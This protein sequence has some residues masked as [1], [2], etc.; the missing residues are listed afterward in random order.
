MKDRLPRY[1]LLLSLY[2]ALALL[3]NNLEEIKLTAGLRV[4]AFS[5]LGAI[6]LTG[7]LKLVFKD[8]Q[9]A[10]LG[11]ALFLLLFFSYGHV[12]GALKASAALGAVVG[13]HRFL[14]PLWLAL[15]LGLGW[16]T[17]YRVKDRGN[18]E[19]GLN[20]IAVI[21]LV[22]PVYQIIAF[23]FRAAAIQA[24]QGQSAAEAHA[25]SLPEGQT[26]PDIYYIILDA[27]ARDDSLLEDYHLDNSPFLEHL[28]ELG[29]FVARCSQS[30]YAQTKL[31]LSSALTMNYLEAFYDNA[32][33]GNTS[34]IGIENYILHPAAREML[35]DLGYQTVAFET[36]FTWSQ[37]NDA[38]YYFSPNQGLFEKLG[39]RG[40]LN[41]FET[42][43]T[44]ST[45][46]VLLT[47]AGQKIPAT[48]PAGGGRSQE[49]HRQRVLY[50]L[51]KLSE[52]PLIPGPKFVFAHI[53]SPHPPY[54]FG[55]D[56]G[57]AIF[58][59]NEVQAYA[60]QVVYLNGRFEAII[61]EILA[62]SETEPIIIIQ[63]DHGGTSAPKDARMQILNAYYFP[64]EGK[65][66]LYA[67]ITP[68]NSFRLVF[69][70]YFGG[71]F[72][73]LEDASY[74][75]HYNAPYEYE[76]VPVVREGCEAK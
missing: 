11:A 17:L 41:D 33:S 34:R 50:V 44:Q 12:Y 38:S 62:N 1:P 2:P 67:N 19:N 7:V 21:L 24:D 14:G 49:S 51:D 29:F 63:G 31:S 74:Y 26:P 48:M 36:G 35:E 46:A 58:S 52:V 66:Q 75:S 60:D 8:W 9:R 25:L 57:K 72:E 18:L 15:L 65:S 3:A 13:R 27:Y 40:G 10:G 42:L 61:A 28:G 55:P 45:A 69:N 68:V 5:L 23:Q 73:M 22:F 47:D 39:I 54:V 71:N 6:V 53:L 20:A 59:A 64:G 37:M 76:I 43:F 32:E 56:D 16:W 30:N 70:T 4:L